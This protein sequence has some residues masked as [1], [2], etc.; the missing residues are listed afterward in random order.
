MPREGHEQFAKAFYAA[1]PDLYH[2]VDQVIANDDGVAVRFTLRGTHKGEFMGIP[3]TGRQVE[4]SATAMM[5][6]VD[7]R[8][9]EVDGIFDQIGLM[10]Q[11]GVLPP[12]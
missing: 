7:G 8:V 12:G 4:V 11:L 5:R 9:A 3:A 1:F 2:T 6:V 10:R